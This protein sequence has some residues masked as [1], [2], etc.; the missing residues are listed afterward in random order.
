MLDLH[1]DWGCHALCTQ[2]S[3]FLVCLL[4]EINWLL[5]LVSFF[6][7]L[8]N[9][10]VGLGPGLFP[11]SLGFIR[12]DYATEQKGQNSRR[13]LLSLLSFLS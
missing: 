4:F 11:D 13:E 7:V 1:H 9:L 8:F 2:G 3:T 5:Q 10:L 12:G 6:L